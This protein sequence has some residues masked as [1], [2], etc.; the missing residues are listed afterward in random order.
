MTEDS[1]ERIAYVSISK[2]GKF[3]IDYVSHATG[4]PK[5][6]TAIGTQLAPLV[7]G[8]EKNKKHYIGE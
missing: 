7:A 8:I 4:E 3:K 6:V 2:D 1:Y 5:L